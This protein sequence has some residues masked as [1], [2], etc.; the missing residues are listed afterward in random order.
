MMKKIPMRWRAEIY[1]LLIAFV[2]GTT[3]I[4]VKGALGFV[5]PYTFLAL[6]FILASIL[7]ACVSYQHLYRIS[8]PEIK[9]G[10]A[11]GLFLIVGFVF[12]TVG[13]QYTSASNTAFITGLSVVIVPIIIS[14]YTSSLPSWGTTCGIVL[15][16]TGLFLLTVT[17]AFYVSYGDILVLGAAFGFAAHIVVVDRWSFHYNTVNLAIVQI[18]A[19]GLFCMLVAIA[20]EPW[21]PVINAPV[22]EALVITSVFG[23]ALAFLVQ[24]TMQK[25]T[26]PTRTAIIFITE[27][28]FGA[29]FAHFWA[30]EVLSSRALV[31]CA[32]IISGMLLTELDFARLKLRRLRQT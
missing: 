5:G 12:Q 26:T 14:I 2:W 21:P 25:Y 3:F 19:V 24:N 22:M 15:A 11:L 7:L 8:W 10:L 23:T 31:G 18:L 6:R 20:Q 28:I 27:P 1:L 9:A 16:T 30:G 4:L 29:A 17:N 13:L 32:L